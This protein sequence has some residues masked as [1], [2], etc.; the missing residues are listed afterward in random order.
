MKQ[1]NY[2]CLP[3]SLISNRALSASDFAVAAYL[4]SLATAYGSQTLVGLSVKVKQVT[5]AER[6][7]IS[8]DTVKRA[9][10][11][12]SSQDIILGKQ[13]KAKFNKNLGTNTYILKSIN[14]QDRYTRISKKAAALLKPSELRVYAVFSMCKENYKNSFFHSLNDL[15]EILHTNK[16]QIIK[17]INIMIKKGVVRKQLRK[18]SCGDYTENKYF[19]VIQ[20]HGSIKKVCA[21]FKIAHTKTVKTVAAYQNIAFYDTA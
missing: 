3:N 7:G 20:V 13:R 17:T 4:Y 10:A 8:V 15:C 14:K 6:C 9:I 21:I 2:F 11:R 16:Q 19:I 1:I 5:I 12:L 18:T